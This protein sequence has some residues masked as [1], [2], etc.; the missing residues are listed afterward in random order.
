MQEVGILQDNLVCMG[1]GLEPEI[2]R[3]IWKIGNK[4]ASLQPLSQAEYERRRDDQKQ[5]LSEH[6]KS[7]PQGGVG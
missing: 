1:P 5:R 3:T 2:Q 7:K 6:L 4:M